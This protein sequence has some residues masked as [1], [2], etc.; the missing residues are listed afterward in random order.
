M[1]AF[2]QAL[3]SAPVRRPRWVLLYTGINVT[4]DISAMVIEIVYTDHLGARSGEI[5][6]TVEDRER[7]WQG[8]WYPAEGDLVNLQ[9]GYA[10]EPLMPCGDFEVDDLQ[11]NG[12]PDVF[13]MRCLAAFIT[14]AMR[15]PNSAGYEN[16]SLAQIAATIAGKYGYAL[17]A[18]PDAFDLVFERVTQ[19]QETDLAFLKRLA[20]MH[21][22]DFTVRG[23]AI[24]FFTRE[25]L[26]QAP[27]VALIARSDVE[28]FSFRSRTHF[29][30][31]AAEVSWFD[32]AGKQLVTQSAEAAAPTGDTF[33]IAARAE[34][35]QQAAL[36]AR[37]ILHE[38]NR[39]RVTAAIAM[40][41]AN[42]LAAGNTIALAGFGVNDGVYI[43]E[44]ARHRLSRETGYTTD[45]EVRSV[46]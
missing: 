20:A 8:P 33:K 11:L 25:A 16:Q 10:G 5:E 26:E 43:I 42:Y 15:T 36:K 29:I 27:P 9:I 18:A 7:R 46:A 28:R 17:I 2:A 12:P 41:G 1:G 19:N 4:A 22:Y 34:N 3:T 31:Q 45:I 35:G 24:V 6:V 37:A 23:S 44:T 21:N 39:V 40:P 38:A 14:P 30:Y 13:T 32:P